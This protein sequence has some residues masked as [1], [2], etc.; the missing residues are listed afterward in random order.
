MF[1]IL[2]GFV[3]D[4]ANFSVDY[5]LLSFLVTCIVFSF[6]REKTMAILSIIFLALI[7]LMPFMEYVPLLNIIYMGDGMLPGVIARVLFV[8]AYSLAM[9]GFIHC[10]VCP[11]KLAPKKAAPRRAAPARRGKR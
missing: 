9:I 5:I 7:G 3:Q 10:F 4:L 1:N 8:A 6:C 2:G 11:D